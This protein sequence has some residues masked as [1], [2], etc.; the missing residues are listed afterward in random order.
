[1]FLCN[2]ACH[3]ANIVFRREKF[4]NYSQTFKYYDALAQYFLHYF[5]CRLTS[6][7]DMWTSYI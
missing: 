5:H 7:L 3:A 6:Y 1:M 4:A 2:N